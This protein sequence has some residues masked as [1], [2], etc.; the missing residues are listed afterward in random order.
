MKVL[1]EWRPRLMEAWGTAQFDLKIDKSVVTALDKELE[2]AIKDA[3]R[4]L[5]SE[6]GFIGEEHG[7]EGPTD[8]YWLVDPIDGTEQ[9]IRGLKACRTLLTYVEGNEA[10]YALAYRFTTD[11]LYTARAG[12]GTYRNGVRIRRPERPLERS[13][14]EISAKLGN[15]D[16][17]KTVGKL[18]AK[19]RTWGY[20]HEFLD[21]VDGGVDAYIVIDG[22]GK[23]WDYAP[24]AL[25]MKETG[26][27]LTNIGSDSYDF[28]D[29]SLIAAHPSIHDE[30]GKLLSGDA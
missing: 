30:I 5:S 7:R 2:P 18:I 4:G 1:K 22:D 6:V 15:P 28:Q 10:L 16:V 3:L 14:I 13:W 29:F 27:A 8:R 12:G 25:L 20:P 26:A 17:Q 23:A 9:F 11:D 19:T 21:A 24:R